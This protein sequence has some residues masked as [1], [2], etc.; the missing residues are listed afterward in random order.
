MERLLCGP[1]VVETVLSHALIMQQDIALFMT[2]DQILSVV[3]E[4][5]AR[6]AFSTLPPVQQAVIPAGMI[7]LHA[8][9]LWQAS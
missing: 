1:A 5:L 4:N 8:L 9:G 7:V 6:Y 2:P 3:V